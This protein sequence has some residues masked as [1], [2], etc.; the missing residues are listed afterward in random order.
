MISAEGERI[1]FSTRNM[2]ARGNV[3]DWLMAVQNGMIDTLEKEMK[4]GRDTYASASFDIIQVLC[5]FRGDRTRGE[6]N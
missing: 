6:P 4:K 2:K 5:D 1:E 3:E